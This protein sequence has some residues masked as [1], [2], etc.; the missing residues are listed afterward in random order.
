LG[1]SWEE[2]F[3][4]GRIS[5]YSM[6]KIIV[7]GSDSVDEDN[8]DN[9]DEYTVGEDSVGEDTVDED[10]VDEEHNGEPADMDR[11]YRIHNLHTDNRSREEGG[12]H[13]SHSEVEVHYNKELQ[14]LE[15]PLKKVQ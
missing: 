6:D 9:K 1:G 5:L 4:A 7:G 2:I 10:T 15:L 8:E 13:G 3:L 11:Y 12:L 14:H